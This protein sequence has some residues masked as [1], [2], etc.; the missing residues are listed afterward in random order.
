MVAFCKDAPGVGWRAGWCFYELDDTLFKT[1]LL[2]LLYY[3]SSGYVFNPDNYVPELSPIYTIALGGLFWLCCLVVF[4]YNTL[5]WLSNR[6]LTIT[7]FVE[8]RKGNIYVNYIFNLHITNKNFLIDLCVQLPH[9]ALHTY[10][11]LIFVVILVLWISESHADISIITLAIRGYAHIMYQNRRLFS[12][13]SN[14]DFSWTSP[15]LE[16]E[17]TTSVVPKPM[18]YQLS[19]PG[20]DHGKNLGMKLRH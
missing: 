10:S 12:Q 15:L 13:H 6:P 3:L 7:L 2:L 19:Y 17:P 1:W 14:L 11:L 8:K 18:R 16:F 5:P 4:A 20:L 9:T